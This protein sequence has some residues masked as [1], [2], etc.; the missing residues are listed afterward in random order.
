MEKTATQE[1]IERIKSVDNIRSLRTWLAKNEKRLLEQE[2][3]LLKSVSVNSQRD[4][5][6]S[7]E[8]YPPQFVV[9]KANSVINELV[10]YLPNSLN[11]TI[12]NMENNTA[13][14]TIKLLLTIVLSAFLFGCNDIERTH[15]R[16][17]LRT[18]SI[19]VNGYQLSIT[20][21]DSCE[22]IVSGSNFSQMITHKGNCKYCTVRN[23]N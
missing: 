14:S 5:I 23:K 12:I 19:D 20:E 11:Q 8:C 7:G 10:N 3:E 17:Q 18:K 22:Y 15:K 2:R 13:K 4:Y 16:E 21:F 1:L 6:T 9:D